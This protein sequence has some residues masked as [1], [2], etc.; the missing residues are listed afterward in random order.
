MDNPIL[1]VGVRI[2]ALH[3]TR[4]GCITGRSTYS[5]RSDQICI[6]INVIVN[7]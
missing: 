4:N 1:G 5:G 3:I 7:C 2:G 6:N